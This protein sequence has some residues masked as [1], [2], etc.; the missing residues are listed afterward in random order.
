MLPQPKTHRPFLWV[1]AVQVWVA[2][3]NRIK[4]NE[5]LVSR[6]DLACVV[7]Y[8][9]AAKLADYQLV[10]VREF[11]ASSLTGSVL[12]LPG[13][14]GAES[15]DPATQ[16]ADELAEEAGLTV[17]LNRL[18]THGARQPLATFSIH[19][20]H[21][22]S[23]ELTAA[24]FVRL[25]TDHETRGLAEDTK[26]TQIELCRYGDLCARPEVDWTTLGVINQ[27]LTALV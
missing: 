6:P 15:V 21:V 17:D 13:G 22:F 4:S 1:L 27:V 5:V 12:E 16:A 24:E 18:R 9:P 8:Y 26:R 19:Q 3:E 20:Q 11:R 14:S 2:A 10:L 7:A 25:A 23:L